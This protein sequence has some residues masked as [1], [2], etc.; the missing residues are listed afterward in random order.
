MPAL[1]PRIVRADHAGRRARRETAA[2][3]AAARRRRR[4]MPPRDCMICSGAGTPALR[5]PLLQIG[6]VAVDH[7]LHVGVEGGDD[8]ALVFAERRIDLARQRDE[9]ASGWRR[10]MIS[11]GAP[12]VRRVEE[13]EQE[14]DRDRLGARRDQRSAARVRTAASSSG[15]STS[16]VAPIRSGTSLRNAPGRQE[17]RRLRLQH[18][19]VH[20]VPHLAADLQHVAEPFG[21]DRARSGR[22]CARA[23][24]WSRPS[25]RGRSARSLRRHPPFRLHPAER[26]EHRDA[27]V[28]GCRRDL[29]Q[30]H[31]AGRPAQTTSVNVPPISTP[32]AN[33]PVVSLIAK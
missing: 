17:Y 24:R 7:R 8:G 12:L 6:E 21:R 19:I 4:Q 29:R 25:C 13:R 3:A 10:A 28:A 15:T 26:L 27:R 2:P 33:R 20:R 5:R 23:R 1:S 18:E 9:A 30:P 11:R 14:H 22:P 16:P 31:A 32:I